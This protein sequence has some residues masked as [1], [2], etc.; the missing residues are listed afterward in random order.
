MSRK[1]KK[2]KISGQKQSENPAK[3]GKEKVW[4]RDLKME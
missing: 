2:W 4:D 1:D 3:T